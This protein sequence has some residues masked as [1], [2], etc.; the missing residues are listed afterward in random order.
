MPTIGVLLRALLIVLA[1]PA[2]LIPQV[3]LRVA[4]AVL[5][6]IEA[7]LTWVI[8][9]TPD[10][11]MTPDWLGRASAMIVTFLVV[12]ARAWGLLVASDLSQGDT[13][14]QVLARVRV[15]DTGNRGFPVDEMVRGVRL[16]L[17]ATPRASSPLSGRPR[18]R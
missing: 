17:S 14:D 11:A 13:W 7:V 12:A 3:P 8:I 15:A 18:S 2:A 10:D 6:G 5:V 4:M 16:I 9:W 1:M